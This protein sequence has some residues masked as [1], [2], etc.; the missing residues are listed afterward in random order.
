MRIW[1]ITIGEPL[2][3]DQGQPR[4]LRTG[5]LAEALV[6]E[7]HEVVFWNSDFDHV[8]K[9]ARFG[10]GKKIKISRKYEIELLSSISYDKNIS[11]R[12]FINHRMLARSFVS[13]CQAHQ[14]PDLIIC[15]LPTVELCKAAIRYALPRGIPLVIDARDMWPDIFFDYIPKHLQWFGKVL[16]WPLFREMKWVCAHAT[17]II[18][19]TDAFVDWGIDYAQRPRSVNDRSFPYGYSSEPPLEKDINAGHKYWHEFGLRAD[20]GEFIIVFFGSFGLADKFTFK[21]VID[22]ARALQEDNV[23]FVFCGEGESLNIIKSYAEGVRNVL[24]PGWVNQPEIWTLMQMSSVGLIPYANKKDFM[25]SVPNKVIEYLSAGLP[26]LSSLKGEVGQLIAQYKVGSI[27]SSSE[28]LTA[29]IRKL[30]RDPESLEQMSHHAADL[31]S[32]KFSADQVYGDMI[33]YL[34][35]IAK[36][37]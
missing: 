35:G 21:Q 30:I 3:T 11:L 32:E 10:H 22:A 24:F 26:L 36:S 29:E 33:E 8:L 9:R 19:M 1:L 14:A 5:I 27:Y 25:A 17:A 28:E 7:G 34:S 37:K 6:K 15:S 18:G 16:L 31:F 2:P 23:K 13:R 20:S 12:R 4:L